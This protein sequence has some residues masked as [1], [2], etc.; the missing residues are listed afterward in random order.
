VSTPN[1]DEESIERAEKH[2]QNK[3]IEKDVDTLLDGL[4]G[5][6][7]QRSSSIQEIIDIVKDICQSYDVT[8]LAI[9]GAYP[10][11]IAMKTSPYLIDSLEFRGSE[12][13]QCLK[14]GSLI[15]EK[16]GIDNIKMGHSS[17]SFVYKNVSVSFSGDTLPIEIKSGLKDQGVDVNSPDID[18]YNRDFTVNMLSYNLMDSKIT[19]PTSKASEDVKNKI[20]RT[21]F[22]PNYVCQQNPI[23]ILRALKLKIRHN[24]E[25]D[26]L[27][28]KAML[29]N[30]SLIF[31]GRYSDVELI[32]ARE[33]VK[34]EGNK[35][36]SELFKTFRLENIEKVN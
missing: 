30:V 25:I 18:L 20:I 1:T 32:I 35:E 15:A 8:D 7:K 10:R 4:T 3:T 24:M 36:A 17:I 33:N 13:D 2:L 6:S 28:Q 11:D 34:K 27:L 14:V 19:D 29:D 5:I 31:D 12:T 9:V 21:A 16:M 23:V 22:D 26:P